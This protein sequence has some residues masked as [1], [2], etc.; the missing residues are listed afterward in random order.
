MKLYKFSKLARFL[1]V[2]IIGSSVLTA[3][4]SLLDNQPEEK[5]VEDKS[6]EEDSL[7]AN[8]DSATVFERCD[9]YYSSE[10]YT[11][12]FKYCKKSAKEGNALAQFNLGY[13]YHRGYGARQEHLDL[14]G[15]MD[16]ARNWFQKAAEQGI[17]EAQYN[18]GYMY[19]NGEGGL[20]NNTKAIEWYQ[21]AADQ[22][23]TSAQYNLG[24]MYYNGQGVKQDYFKAVEWW[25]KAADQGDVSAQYNL[26]IM[27]QYGQGVKQNYTKAK[28]YF[29]LAC[30]NKDQK[31]CDIYKE[32]NQ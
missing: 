32:L 14:I 25:Q 4:C 22:G 8:M 1:S 12:A 19:N 9:L 24:L 23:H 18:L 5:T 17:V 3:G 20:L 28:E 2:A 26:G 29:G 21:K 10:N 11:E 30:D 27:Y 13:M 31:G 15:A 6:K 16:A 7:I